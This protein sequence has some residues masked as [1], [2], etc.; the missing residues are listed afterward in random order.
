VFNFVTYASGLFKLKGNTDGTK[1]GNVGD[2][3][4]VDA[5]VSVPA[6]TS[7]LRYVD[8]NS[9]SGGVARNTNISTDWTNIFSYSGSGNLVGFFINVETLPT[10]WV[11][12]LLVDGASIFEMSGEDMTG[13]GLYDLDDVTDSNQAMLGISKGSHDRFI[14]HSPLGLPIQYSSSVVVRLKRSTG[15]KKFQAGLIIL[16]KET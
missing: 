12:S 3:L 8:M 11:F 10:G 7:T 4:K 1:I 5:K 9:S 15:S 13:D 16:S 6:L 2:R 14:W